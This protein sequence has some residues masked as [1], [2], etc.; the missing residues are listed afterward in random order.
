MAWPPK[1]GDYDETANRSDLTTLCVAA[2]YEEVRALLQ[3][4]V[5][6]R[7]PSSGLW[8]SLSTSGRGR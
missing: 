3:G 7:Q 8:G 2:T 5:Q 4:L 1:A 6:T